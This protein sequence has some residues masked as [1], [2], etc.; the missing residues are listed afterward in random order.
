MPLKINQGFNRNL[1]LADEPQTTKEKITSYFNASSVR[2]K[3]KSKNTARN[4]ITILTGQFDFPN[5][6]NIE[7]S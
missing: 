5:N 6:K 3:N 7:K 1:G 2:F 4:K